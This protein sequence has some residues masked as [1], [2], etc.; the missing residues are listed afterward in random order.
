[1]KQVDDEKFQTAIKPGDETMAGEITAWSKTCK[2][3]SGLTKLC[4]EIILFEEILSGLK[5]F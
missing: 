4:L 3:I 2:S 5:T 1:M